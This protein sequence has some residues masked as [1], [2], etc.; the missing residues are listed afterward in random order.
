MHS[1]STAAYSNTLWLVVS[2]QKERALEHGFIALDIMSTHCHA[3]R[4]YIGYLCSADALIIRTD[5]DSP[6]GVH[7]RGVPLYIHTGT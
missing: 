7:N 3:Y 6:Y 4:K 2:E 1:N 5:D